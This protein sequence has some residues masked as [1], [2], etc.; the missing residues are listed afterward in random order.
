MAV[1]RGNQS[2]QRGLLDLCFQ[3]S[4]LEPKTDF[5]DGIEKTVKWYKE[6]M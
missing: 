5:F 6:V 3:Y 2:G 1:A 4:L